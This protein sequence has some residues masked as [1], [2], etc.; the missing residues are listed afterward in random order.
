MTGVHLDE[1][2]V[3]CRSVQ[4]L[5]VAFHATESE[6]RRDEMLYH[7]FITESSLMEMLVEQQC[8]T[9]TG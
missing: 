8:I 3:Q 4:T 5:R 9:Q 6:M 1:D 7:F 2:C